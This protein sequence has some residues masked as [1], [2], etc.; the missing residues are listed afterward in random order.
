VD[1]L[2]TRLHA[3]L[4]GR[5]TIERELGRGG[6]AVV[7]LAHDVKHDR[8]VAVKVLRPEIAAALGPERFLREVQ[9]TARLNHPHI[10]PLLDSG[11]A[12]GFLY[13]VM[14]YVEGESLRAR[15]EREAQL[16]LEE[17]LQI[18]REAADALGYAHCHDV[19]H[20][21]V[22]PENIL[23][24]SGHAIV[25]DFGIAR[26]ITE[27]ESE[28]R[29][30]PGIAV[31]TPQ[32][33]SPE[34]A[35]GERHLD[36]RSDIYSLG[37][38]AYEMLAGEP[39]FT[40]RSPE[41]IRARRL[42]GPPPSLATMRPTI[43]PI[44]EGAI[45]AALALVPADRYPTAAAFAAALMTTH[46]RRARVWRWSSR[47][48]LTL[49]AAAVLILAAPLLWRALRPSTIAPTHQ[50][51]DPTHVAVLYF[52]DLSEP[53]HLGHVAAGL[54]QN[55]IDELL[56][57][58]VLTV[59]SPDGVRQF[60]GQ[61]IALDT[62]ARRLGAGTFVTGS[63]SES[64]SGLRV[65]VRLTDP[66][67][68][69]LLMSQTV[70]RPRGDIIQILEEVS[71]EVSRG[72]RQRLGQVIELRERRAGTRSA[73]AWELVRR[74]EALRDEAG[75]TTD[76]LVG[77]RALLE[78][79]SLLAR[80]EQM[81]PRW[82]EPVVL[83]GWLAYDQTTL[84]MPGTPMV[85]VSGG[86]TTAEWIRL[87]LRRAERAL[88]L[89]PG[90]PEA[91]E[92]R[93]TIYY[94]I[95]SLSPALAFPDIPRPLEAAERDLRI[96]A[97]QPFR[98]QARAWS[99]LS[100]V[101]EQ[102]GEYAESNHAAQRAHEADAYLRDGDTIVFR[103][104][105]TAFELERPAEAQRWCQE[106]RRSYPANWYFS[107]CALQ[108]Q[109]WPLSRM[110]GEDAWRT[111]AEVRQA[112]APSDWAWLGPQV[113][114]MAAAV[115]ARAGLADSANHVLARARAQAPHDPQLLY[116]EAVARLRLGQP[117]SAL[118][119]IA[120]LI[121]ASPQDKAYLRRH[122]LLHPLWDDPRFQSLMRD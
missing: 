64:Q 7:Y 102:A 55:L 5:Y 29:T 78:A 8:A 38:V 22:K 91:L 15:L 69:Q 117:D 70:Q 30:E 105:K 56:Q 100:L 97:A 18:T 83:R 111:V 75:E 107:Y 61:S 6:M 68:G 23:L 81:D 9:I 34:Q 2:F 21:D 44:V 112:A 80:A 11:E 13:Y 1:K 76:L 27:A 46:E 16:P 32:Y 118:K 114:M 119:L 65:A 66:Q 101:L 85:G 10:L 89:R 109:G 116:Y 121:R 94:R 84:L 71:A 43:P 92:L 31:G 90:D 45:N 77:G 35:M 12:D 48:R 62:I 4:I 49:W 110:A 37:C 14:P 108:L 58:P 60:R 57:V 122:T 52:E 115:L 51:L 39:P 67:T 106:G 99:R 40:G 95:A 24:E 36:G 96:A 19:V 87:G 17:A 98:F 88:Q 73:P 86:R 26:A 41:A 53:A 82:I 113:D 50:P 63:V 120:S 20:R 47:K 103:L 54:T 42:Q 74:A 33:M 28:K 59:T 104:Y 72:L 93:G 25:A 3:A 79:D